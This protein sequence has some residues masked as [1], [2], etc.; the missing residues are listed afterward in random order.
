MR[1][2]AL[3]WSF[4]I[5]GP[6]FCSQSPSTISG[7]VVDSARRL[8]GRDGSSAG[9]TDGWKKAASLGPP[10]FSSSPRLCRQKAASFMSRPAPTRWCGTA[11]KR[12]VSAAGLRESFSHDTV[13][14][15]A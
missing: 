6:T 3:L 14:K 9:Q 15:V 4:L 1:R 13:R 5:F 2:I 8:A 11:G 7:T 12:A 10:F